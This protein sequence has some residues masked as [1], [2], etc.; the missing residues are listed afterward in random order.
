MTESNRR[1]ISEL[2]AR[3]EFEPTLRDLYVEGERDWFLL[4]WFFRSLHLDNVVVYL[5]AGVD[6]PPRLLRSLGVA[7][8]KGRVVALC[9]QMA[10]HL[11][12]DARNLLGLIDKDRDDLLGVSFSSRFLV[13]TDFSCIEC[14][15]LSDRALNKFCAVYLGKEISA[16]RRA[17]LLNLAV[18]SF[19]LRTAKLI[20][21]NSAGWID[22]TR[23]CT[24]DGTRISFDRDD[25]IERLCHVSSSKF[26][27]DDLRTKFSE[28]FEVRPADLLQSINGHEL[29]QILSW[30]AHAI[31]VPNSICNPEPLQRALMA[32]IE[33]E[34]LISMPLFQRLSDWAK[35]S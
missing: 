13:T 16:D 33:L 21:S 3:Y 14:Y 6:V 22:I 20:L 30:F 31:G 25:F 34:E 29:V 5:I 2:V 10:L 18:E 24:T 28:L 17:E 4:D 7:G 27:R 23:C 1:S 9:E 32:S 12:N 26:S 35:G 11:N 19:V 15:G 8:N